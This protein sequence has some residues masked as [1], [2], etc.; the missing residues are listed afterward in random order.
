MELRTEDA[1]LYIC[2]KYAYL[3]LKI[4]LSLVHNK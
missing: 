3:Y 4:E 2:V 1:Y